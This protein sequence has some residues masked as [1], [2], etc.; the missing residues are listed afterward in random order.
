M[1]P[2]YY[3]QVG[4][5]YSCDDAEAAYK[6]WGMNCGP[7]AIAAVVRMTPDE[8]RPHMG[9]FERK[10]YTNPTLMFAILRSLGV[11]WRAIDRGVWPGYGLVRIQWHGPWMNEGVPIPARYRHTHW[12]GHRDLHGGGHEIFDINCIGVGGWIPREEWKSQFVPWFLPQVE[13]KSDGNWSMTHVLEIVSGI[14]VAMP[15]IVAR[16]EPG[17]P[18]LETPLP[19]KGPTV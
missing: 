3:L 11:R 5:P 16:R 19:T 10:G 17:I 8:L 15:A 1:K 12:I 9:D 7:G 4:L 2:D 14:R 18:A 13:P 6:E